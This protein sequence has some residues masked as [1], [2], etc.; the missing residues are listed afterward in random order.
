M[1]ELFPALRKELYCDPETGILPADTCDTIQLNGTT[2]TNGLEKN[3]EIDIA[4]DG[5]STKNTTT[6]RTENSAEADNTEISNSVKER[7]Q[8]DEVKSIGIGANKMNNSGQDT[9]ATIPGRMDKPGV[10]GM[11]TQQS[12]TDLQSGG[13]LNSRTKGPD[14]TDT[15]QGGDQATLPKQTLTLS[16]L[17]GPGGGGDPGAGSAG[18][19]GQDTG[20]TS[21]EGAGE[22]ARGGQHEVETL[23]H[24][25]PPLSESSLT[26]PVLP[27]AYLKITFDDTSGSKVSALNYVLFFSSL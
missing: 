13:D 19:K 23:A 11:S 15:Q 17:E 26:L 3:L 24:S 6:S 1:E 8:N 5:N 25:I 18:V 14:H 7:N 27:A 2:S 16:T 12:G 9:N 10:S 20:V 4:T 22:G 21:M